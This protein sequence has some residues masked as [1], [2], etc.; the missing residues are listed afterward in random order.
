[1]TP[2]RPVLDTASDAAVARREATLG[3]VAQL[4]A[5][6]CR[7]A[8]A[9]ARGTRGWAERRKLAPRERLAHLLDP[10]RPFLPLCTLAGWCVD[11]ENPATSIP[12]GSQLAGIG[13]VSGVRCM[14]VATDSGIA[15][16]ALSEM[17][18]QKLLRCQEIALENRLP[19]VHLVESAGANLLK[20]RVEKFVRGGAIFRNL[21]LL[22][23]AGLPVVT[24]VHGPSAAGGAYMPG[25]SDYVVMIQGHARAYLAGPSLLRAATGE[26][27]DDE[28]LGGAGMHA[29]ISGLCE[30]LAADDAEGIARARDI[31]AALDWPGRAVPPPVPPRPPRHEPE[32][33]AGIMPEDFREP[34]D[35][36]E[37]IARLADD[38]AFLPFKPDYGPATV[39][40][41][42]RLEGH[43]LGIITNNGPLDPAGAAKAAHFIQTC[44]QSGTPIL[45][46]QNTTGFIVG[47][48]SEE[49]GMVK[50]GAKLIQALTNATVP[51]VTIMCGASFGAGNYGMCGRAFRPRFLFSWPGAR[52]AVMGA[53][54]AATTMELVARAQAT[55][56]GRPVDEDRLAAQR[57]A[58]VAN[59]DSQADAFL[60]SGLLLDDGV[61]D[62]RDTRAVLAFVF[63]TCREAARATPNRIQFG[64]ARP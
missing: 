7:A 30:Y 4:R 47:R 43:A 53:E 61:I 48:T 18:N 39:C 17:G 16:G 26:I 58:I 51:Q 62:P 55:R 56:R 22:S 34:V 45:Y 10:S 11:D 13:F 23:A 24:V 27:T 60:T 19:F 14:V 64:V 35:M 28:A 12:G 38:S 63:D 15:G 50:H 41:R 31:V 1:M 29:R 32:E 6:E 8:E 46:L 59:F 3:R 2:L 40:G 44:C 33:L 36:R 9:S 52:T 20:Y 37:V 25:L 21:A 49:A 57:A 54:Q 42:A 5:L